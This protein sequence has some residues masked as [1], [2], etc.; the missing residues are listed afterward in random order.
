VL[1]TPFRRSIWCPCLVRV[2]G[3]SESAWPR[4]N[5][6]HLALLRTGISVQKSIHPARRLYSGFDLALRLHHPEDVDRIDLMF[7]L[8]L[9]M[10]AH[11]GAA[12]PF[13]NPPLPC[14]T[15]SSPCLTAPHEYESLQVLII[16]LTERDLRNSAQP[17]FRPFYTSSKEIDG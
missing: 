5:R 11:V 16:V 17:L 15:C 1:P 2:H 4:Q 14:P 6:Q 8:C 12:S 3:S 7:A 10:H 9:L 13:P